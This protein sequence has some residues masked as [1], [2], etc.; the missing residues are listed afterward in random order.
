MNNN[1]NYNS[2]NYPGNGQG[3]NQ[4]NSQN[5]S[6][7]SNQNYGQNFNQNGAQNYGQNYNQSSAQNYGQNGTGYNSEQPYGGVPGYSGTGQPMYP[8]T[9][10][11]MMPATPQKSKAPVAVI[12]AVVLVVL[13]CIGYF[14]EKSFQKEDSQSANTSNGNN[15]AVTDVNGGTSV[16]APVPEPEEENVPYSKGV[17]TANS[18]ESK[19]VGIRYTTPSGWINR[20]EA[21]NKQMATAANTECE[22]FS[23]RTS[24]GCNMILMIETLPSENVTMDTYLQSIRSVIQNTSGIPAESIKD[25]GTYTIAGKDYETISFENSNDNAKFTQK[26]YLR[27]SGDRIIA[28]L[29]TMTSSEVESEF[30]ANVKAY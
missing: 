19:F 27:K 9:Q 25:S 18:Y 28:F 10:P 3:Y 1:Q 2:N 30:F 7:N 15:V 4:N 6:Q 16:P 13:A 24:D 22:L 20:S 26:Y 11:G 14:A 29:V 23:V 17:V 5:Y 21:E 8:N 12:V